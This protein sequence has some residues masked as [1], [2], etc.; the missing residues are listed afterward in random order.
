MFIY[1]VEQL[2]CKMGVLFRRVGHDLPEQNS[3]LLHKTK[4]KRFSKRNIIWILY[5]AEIKP[6]YNIS[7]HFPVIIVS[8]FSVGT[9]FFYNI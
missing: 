8:A 7:L 2:V 6:I 1:S 4:W 9:A 5:V 3:K